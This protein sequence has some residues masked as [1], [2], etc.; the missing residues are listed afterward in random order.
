MRTIIREI[1]INDIVWN[2]ELT[3]GHNE[4]RNRTCYSLYIS[5]PEE[6]YPVTIM[7]YSLPRSIPSNSINRILCI[8]NSS[9]YSLSLLECKRKIIKYLLHGKT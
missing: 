9:E 7:L 2:I 1:L 4:R 6:E 8:E 3:Y 5:K